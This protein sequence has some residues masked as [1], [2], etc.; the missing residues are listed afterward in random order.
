MLSSPALIRK[1]VWS[2]N[3][4]RNNKGQ[5]LRKV[6]GMEVQNLFATRAHVQFPITLQGARPKRTRIRTGRNTP[7][8][9]HSVRAHVLQTRLDGAR[10]VTRSCVLFTKHPQPFAELLV[11]ALA[12]FMLLFLLRFLQ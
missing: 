3:H 12:F 2:G 5:D 9:A 10:T 4:V 11:V 6:L 7:V 8:N 1:V